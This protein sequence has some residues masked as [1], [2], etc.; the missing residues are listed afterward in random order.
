LV[1]MSKLQQ[2]PAELELVRAFVNSADLEQGTDEFQNSAALAGW[3][4]R[5]GLLDG[6]AGPVS[7]DVVRAVAL[8]EALRTVLLSNTQGT[9]VPSAASQTLDMA[10]R[11]ARLRL[12][13]APGGATVLESE[14]D[15]VDGALGRLLA[16]VHDSITRGTWTR[17]KACRL[18][19]CEWAFYDHT[20]NRS[21]AWC[22]MDVCGNRAKARAYRERRAPAEA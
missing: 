5:H 16:I 18:P 17:L 21:G 10:A 14:S 20:K 15:G 1:V 6:A 19:S 4:A 12:R 8:R 13:F 2:A 3:L 22:N 7:A 11:R 9:P